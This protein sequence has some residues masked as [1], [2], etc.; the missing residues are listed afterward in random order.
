MG[1]WGDRALCLLGLF[2]PGALVCGAAAERAPRRFEEIQNWHFQT[3]EQRAG[4]W[5][6]LD[7]FRH[8]KSPFVVEASFRK[9][10]MKLFIAPLQIMSYWKTFMV[11]PLP[12]IFKTVIYISKSHL[13][14]FIF[15]KWMLEDPDFR[16][17]FVLFA[18]I[19]F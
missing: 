14:E 15:Q 5:G 4:T 10:K 19:F 11:Q 8:R 17:S 1:T 9:G 6:D 13:F 7:L 3:K 12:L 2:I 18:S 16:D